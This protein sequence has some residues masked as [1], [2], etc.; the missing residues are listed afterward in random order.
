MATP[1]GSPW[2]SSNP[3]SQDIGKP[4]ETPF[5]L[6]AGLY[7]TLGW[8]LDATQLGLGIASLSGKPA[9]AGSG[10]GLPDGVYAALPAAALHMQRLAIAWAA[11]GVVVHFWFGLAVLMRGTVAA[12]RGVLVRACVSWSAVS[13]GVWVLYVCLQTG[14]SDLPRVAGMVPACG[15]EPGL[16][17]CRALV[18]TWVM[19][20]VNMSVLPRTRWVCG[21]VCVS[22]GG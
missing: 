18:A 20:L 15:E 7:L 21:G 3:T 22:K 5:A 1:S 10:S 19:G 13:L 17:Q 12:A 4:F 14:V 8:P 6:I 9:V 11:G 16:S 2:F